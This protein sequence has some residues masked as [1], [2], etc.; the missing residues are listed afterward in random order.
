MASQTQDD[1]FTCKAPKISNTACTSFS[2]MQ[3][4]HFPAQK[5]WALQSAK[6]WH[7]ETSLTTERSSSEVG[8]TKFLYHW[9]HAITSNIFSLKLGYRITPIYLC[10]KWQMSFLSYIVSFHHPN[11]IIWCLF[12]LQLLLTYRTPPSVHCKGNGTSNYW[13]TCSQYTVA[14]QLTDHFTYP[15]LIILS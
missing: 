5:W 3:T 6:E 2:D 12:W 7:K 8:K 13:V 1:I 9:C 14:I 10:L 11:N 15:L 4:L